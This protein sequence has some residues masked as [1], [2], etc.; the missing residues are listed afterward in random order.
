MPVAEPVTRATLRRSFMLTTRV[1]IAEAYFPWDF[2]CLQLLTL[3]LAR[4][5]GQMT[6]QL[7]REREG[8]VLPPQIQ[9][10]EKARASWSGRSMARFLLWWACM[11]RRMSS[12]T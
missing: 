9:G 2:S 5:G 7:K 4:T 3:G 8:V 10:A 6:C 12:R 11:R 1:R